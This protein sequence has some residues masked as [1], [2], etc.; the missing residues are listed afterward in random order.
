MEDPLQ[1]AM[2]IAK[3]R[4]ALD[5]M[6]ARHAG[7]LGELRAEL[8]RLESALE[9]AKGPRIVIDPSPA[10]PAEALPV[11]KSISPR[12]EPSNFA[13]PGEVEAASAVSEAPRVSGAM[14]LAKSIRVIPREVDDC[15]EKPAE[16]PQPPPLPPA[17]DVTADFE[18]AL[19]RVWLVRIGIVL[20]ITGLVLLGNHLYRNWLRELPAGARLACLFASALGICAAG[21]WAA[22]REKTRAYG[23]MVLAGGMAFFHWCAYAAHHVERLRVIDSVVS[24]SLAMMASAGGIVAVAVKRDSRAI[25]VMGLL[26]ASY[27]TI[28]QPLGTLS[29]VSNIVLGM[30][31]VGLMG[32]KQWQAPGIAAMAGTYAAFLFWAV[33]GAS[34]SGITA[35]GPWFVAALWVVFAVPT[36]FPGWLG[37]LG[38]RGMAWWAGINNAAGFGLFSACGMILE[39]QEPWRIAAAWGAVWLAVALWR[40]RR[41]PVMETYLVQ[42]LALLS[43]ALCLYF[44]GWHLALA[45]AGESL[46][47]AVAHHRFRK[48]AE[49]IFSVL[50]AMLAFLVGLEAS[51]GV[52]IWGGMAGLMLAAGLLLRKSAGQTSLL[53]FPR[54]ASM[55][56]WF[57]GVASG[58]LSMNELPFDWPIFGMALTSLLI[59]A[60]VWRF[61]TTGLFPEWQGAAL[62][63]GG[64]AAL[65]VISDPLRIA[66][67]A[68]AVPILLIVAAWWERKAGLTVT[69]ECPR[70]KKAELFLC[71]MIGLTASLAAVTCLERVL[72]PD[73]RILSLSLLGLLLPILA[74][75][76]KLPRQRIV[77]LLPLVMTCWKIPMS[78]GLSSWTALVTA[79]SAGLA[80]HFAGRGEDRKT[81]GH[82]LHSLMTRGTGFMA[83]LGFCSL[84]WPSYLADLFALS[85]AA[86][87][88]LWHRFF[89]EHKPVEAVGWTILALVGFAAET[90]SHLFVASSG[91]PSGWGLCLALLTGIFCRE[92][93]PR[94]RWARSLGIAAVILPAI[95]ASNWWIGQHGWASVTLL[96]TALGSAWVIY[97]ILRSYREVRL[98]GLL[99]LLAATAKLFVHDVWLFGS[100]IRISAF[101]ALGLALTALGFFYNRFTSILR[102]LVED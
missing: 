9:K 39:W 89:R 99:L 3:L 7:E 22:A 12:T 91:V 23:E 51:P 95:W 64:W 2:Q 34:G 30:A 67:L 80:W 101:L 46:A 25:A 60:G 27:S 24:G 54:Q 32:R 56:V 63:F 74:H 8:R 94:A 66:P 29:A 47:M 15:P 85:A 6:A 42:G 76:Q 86:S 92:K 36:G 28:L 20:L 18:I 44:D 45:L 26:L 21:W 41:S 97:G 61:R 100:F 52:F 50:A 38:P 55:T 71:W 96:W 81:A 19:G 59:V 49:R 82:S 75:R 4:T 83:W 73:L 70:M 90:T 65:L 33:A 10:G 58:L 1:P 102:R 79:M 69:E 98:A 35:H 53:E 5:E 93:N 84:L 43:V 14:R 48:A 31:A 72:Q 57:I 17:R 88:I 62:A 87:W 78:A 40:G 13:E 77:W 11:S 37:N 16:G 68:S